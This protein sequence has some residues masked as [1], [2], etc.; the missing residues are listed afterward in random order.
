MDDSPEN[1]LH[2]SC[3]SPVLL[4]SSD[5][6]LLSTSKTSGECIIP[7]LLA[8][9]IFTRPEDVVFFMIVSAKSLCSSRSV[10]A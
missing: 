6:S 3:T 7:F 5:F 9:I 2:S 8:A 1:S 10:T 4:S